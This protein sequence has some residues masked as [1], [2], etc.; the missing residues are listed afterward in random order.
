MGT[1]ASMS[2]AAGEATV[3]AGSVVGAMV[4]VLAVVLVVVVTVDGSVGCGDVVA[5]SS[6]EPEHAAALR[7]ANA[8]M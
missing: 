6:A 7:T 5:A 1:R 2:S 8:A 3:V 4:V